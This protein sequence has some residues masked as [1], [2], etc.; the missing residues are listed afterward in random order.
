MRVSVRSV[1]RCATSTASSSLNDPAE[2]NDASSAGFRNR[3]MMEQDGPLEAQV[4]MLRQQ[5][6]ILKMKRLE[7]VVE[8]LEGLFSD[9]R[10]R[11]MSHDAA[12]SGA[13]NTA[14]MLVVVAGRKPP[15]RAVS[16]TMP[17]QH[18]DVALLEQTHRALLQA[19]L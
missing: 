11:D 8:R 12:L 5:R 19:F 1:A 17:T 3:I 2:V 18:S 4:E 9:A 13:F 7:V 16:P 14:S 15:M 10:V 6:V